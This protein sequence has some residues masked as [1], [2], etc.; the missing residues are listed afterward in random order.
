M[1]AASTS[2]PPLRL[3]GGH[4]GSFIVGLLLWFILFSYFVISVFI[5][6]LVLI[7]CCSQPN[8]CQRPQLCRVC[9]LALD[10]L[11]TTEIPPFCYC[12]QD[13]WQC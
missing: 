11:R 9:T 8:L 3:H 4:T 5:S 6:P 2:T 13:N 1:S 10:K 12:I 7:L